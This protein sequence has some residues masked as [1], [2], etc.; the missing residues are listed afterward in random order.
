MDI[1]TLNEED[2]EVNFVRHLKENLCARS[3][4]AYT[5]K[6]ALGRSADDDIKTYLAF[7]T[8][9]KSDYVKSKED[10]YF[11]VSCLYFNTERLNEQRNVYVKT[12]EL[13]KR[14]Y[15]QSNSAKKN[16]SRLLTSNYDNVFTSQFVRLLQQMLNVMKNNEK[17]DYVRLLKDLKA[18]NNE[19]K[20][21][22][23]R[24]AEKIT[25]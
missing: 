4:Q 14:I 2:I 19:D 6:H 22:Q 24:W 13:L 10:V 16:I 23:R 18:W 20:K 25:E 7:L 3:P 12:E 1:N 17:L 15:H 11:L 21:V 5:L 9:A 8:V